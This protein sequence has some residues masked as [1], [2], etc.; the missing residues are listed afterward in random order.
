MKNEK[1]LASTI[2]PNDVLLTVISCLLKIWIHSTSSVLPEALYRN[3]TS[4]LSSDPVYSACTLNPLIRVGQGTIHGPTST[5]IHAYDH[6]SDYFHFRFSRRLRIFVYGR[7]VD[8]RRIWI[9]GNLWSAWTCS[10]G[11]FYLY[12]L[13]IRILTIYD[14]LNSWTMKS[15]RALLSTDL[16]G[17]L[18]WAKLLWF[19]CFLSNFPESSCEVRENWVYIEVPFQHHA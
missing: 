11:L 4:A 13:E 6:R 16:L 15:L 14:P 2:I 3:V 17:I 19:R 7:F 18:D 5:H 8:Q 9:L 12:P 1:S 10:W